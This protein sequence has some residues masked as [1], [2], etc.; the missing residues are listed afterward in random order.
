MLKIAA[1]LLIGSASAG[2]SLAHA[3][4]A[5]ATCISDTAVSE[6]PDLSG[7][8]VLDKKHSDDPTHALD[9]AT[10]SMGRFRR[11]AARKRIGEAMKPA[12]TLRIS[13]AGDTIALATSGR[14]HL[15][16]VPG[17]E[18]KTR[19][20]EKG[21]SVQLASAWEGDTL[22]VKTTSDRFAREARYSLESGGA[23]IRV[24][25]TMSGSGSG[26]PIHYALVYRRVEGS[27]APS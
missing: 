4:V 5:S 23:A 13:A 14:L 6:A 19:T 1:L 27:A 22:V 16:T 10:A 7:T 12:D 20:G 9:D 8:Y 11:N 26:E 3:S 18:A 17:A 21:G 15:T 2:A 24:A 25:I